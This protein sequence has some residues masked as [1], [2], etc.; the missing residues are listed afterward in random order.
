VLRLS[1]SFDVIL[2]DG[3]DAGDEFAH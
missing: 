3:I 2:K 1:R